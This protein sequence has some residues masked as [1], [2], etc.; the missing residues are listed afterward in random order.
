MKLDHATIVTGELETARRFLCSVAGLSEGP[1]PAFDV[2]G[3]WFYTNGQPAVHVIEAADRPAATRTPARIDHLALRIDDAT[4]W[5]ALIELI[6]AAEVSYEFAE[7][8]LTNERQLFVALA[9]G[10]VIEFV[11]S[12]HFSIT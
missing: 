5:A 9:P 11:A 4:E 2:S 6:R 3:R 8:P 1:R 12:Q 10:V 7:V